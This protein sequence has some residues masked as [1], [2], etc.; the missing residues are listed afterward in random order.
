MPAQGL[1]D[2]SDSVYHLQTV[3]E[4]GGLIG[5][6]VAVGIFQNLNKIRARRAWRSLGITG[7]TGHPQPPPLIPTHLGGFCH[8]FE[9]SG[10]KLDLEPLSQTKARQFRFGRR[11]LVGTGTDCRRRRTH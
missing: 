5:L 9:L 8:P 2:G 10:K 7:R 3:R 1:V 4:P 6:A 11:H